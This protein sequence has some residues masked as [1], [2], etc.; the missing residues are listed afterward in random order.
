M[1][2]AQLLLQAPHSAFQLTHTDNA[3]ARRVGSTQGGGGAH[4][5]IMAGGT[6]GLQ[7]QV[8]CMGPQP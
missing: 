1:P 5:Q 4:L 6:G 3:F 8:P 2:A 7:G